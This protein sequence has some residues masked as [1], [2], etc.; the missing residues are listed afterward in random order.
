MPVM[1]A[2]R[3]Y[4]EVLS[5][6][7]SANG[8][9]IKRAYKK[10]ALKYHPDRN[11]GDE[12]A[13]AR[14]KEA[15]EAYEVLS[16]PDK[17]A[18]YDRY[19]HAGVKG[20]RGRGPEFQDLGDIF[21]QFGDIF[22]DLFGGGRRRSSGGPRRGANLQTSLTITLLE[23]AEGC[24]KDIEV[25]RKKT[26]RQCHGTGAEPGYEPETCDYCGGQ[27]QIIQAQGFFRVQPT[28]PAC[29]G[30]GKIVRHKCNH[31]YGAGVEDE[32]VTL[33]VRVPAGI[34]NGM[35]LCLRGEGAAGANGGPRGDLYV[36][37]RVKEHRFLKREGRH[38]VCEVPIT[39]TQAA[40]GTEVEIPLLRGTHKLKIPAGTQPGEVIRVRGKGVPDTRTSRPGDLHA[41]IKLVVPKK[42]D[43]EHEECLRKLAEVEQSRVSP[44]EKSWF[45]RVVDFFSGEEDRESE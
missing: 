17:R 20:A 1:P 45:E 15:A 4:Y 30:A 43:A 13:V 42:L 41:V 19:G 31:C 39:Y 44:H 2:Q 10:L 26:C 24:E 35:Q 9:E 6:N 18:R 11:P 34:D 33:T 28:C 27:G 23:A 12:E 22:G 3:D 21:D 14:F 8:D 16:D 38:L 25:N 7:R 36:D 5:V 40:L 29:R 32:R 37:I